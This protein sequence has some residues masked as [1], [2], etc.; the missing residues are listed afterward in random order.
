[1]NSPH[2]K[3]HQGSWIRN[4]HNDFECN[5]ATDGL[6]LNNTDPDFAVHITVVRHLLPYIRVRAKRLSSYSNQAQ[7]N[8]PDYLYPKEA[9]TLQ[10]ANNIEYGLTSAVFIRNKARDLRFDKQIKADV[11]HFDQRCGEKSR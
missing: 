9:H 5:V 2:I 8:L 3:Q 6:R 7:Q 10:Q 1:M 4:V 11:T